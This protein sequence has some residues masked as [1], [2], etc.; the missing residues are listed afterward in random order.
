MKKQF[1][2]I[3]ISGVIAGLLL[4]LGEGILNTLFL[5]QEWHEMNLKL[6]LEEPSQ[7][8]LVLVLI[9]LFVLGFFIM[10]LY[11]VMCHKYGRTNKAALVAGIFIGLLIWGWVL[12]GLLMAGYV[13]NYIAIITFTWGMVE[14]PLITVISS[15]V[16]N[17]IAR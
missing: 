13:N 17:K 8:I 12:A 11:D 9:K 7:A 1:K 4:V 15:K 14:L 10:W 2:P 16:F 5:K 6:G 3:L